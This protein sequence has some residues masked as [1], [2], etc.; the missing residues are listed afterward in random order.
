MNKPLGTER[1][2]DGVKVC[3]ISDYNILCPLLVI[4]DF[5]TLDSNHLLLTYHVSLFNSLQFLVNLEWK[6][7]E[8]QWFGR[9]KISQTIVL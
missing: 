5:M 2:P 7:L 6:E 8:N 9:R 3:E 4:M 1:V